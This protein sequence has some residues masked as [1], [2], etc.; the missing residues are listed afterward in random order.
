MEK[1]SNKEANKKFMLEYAAA[2]HA[3]ELAVLKDLS[4]RNKKMIQELKDSPYLNPKKEGN[5]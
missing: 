5:V 1:N 4:N 3:H 2:I